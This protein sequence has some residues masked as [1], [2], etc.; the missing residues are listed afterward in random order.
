MAID[1]KAV[2]KR[3]NMIRHRLGL[4]ME[5]FGIKVDKALKSNVSKWERGDS[6]PNNSRIKIIA[7]LGEMSIDALLYGSI[8]EKYSSLID[9]LKEKLTLE[10]IDIKSE[11]L[12]EDFPIVDN[13]IN[14][15]NREFFLNHKTNLIFTKSFL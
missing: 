14:D 3:I 9:E 1:K 7:E 6:L 8:Y 4:T 5:E 2:G 11:K 15:I 12:K 13:I 10:Y